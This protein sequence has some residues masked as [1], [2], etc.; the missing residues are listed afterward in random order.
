MFIFKIAKIQPENYGR[1]FTTGIDIFSPEEQSKMEER[2]KRFGIQENLNKTHAKED[3]DLYS[4][5]D[6]NLYGS[7]FNF[8]S[9]LMRSEKYKR[10]FQIDD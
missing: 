3:T 5:F 7:T 9:F 1:P 6:E 4:R 8:I 10:Q 2:A